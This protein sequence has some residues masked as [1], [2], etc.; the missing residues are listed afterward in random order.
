[1]P[2]GPMC[3]SMRGDSLSG[4]R[5]LD[6]LDFLMVFWTS[7]GVMMIGLSC[8]LFLVLRMRLQKSLVGLV[9]AG[10]LYCLFKLFATFL[11]S[12]KCLSLKATLSF[13]FFADL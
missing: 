10:S 11:G 2:F 8:T 12:V 4:P 5:A 3:L 13:H 6:A 1:M 7:A 9:K